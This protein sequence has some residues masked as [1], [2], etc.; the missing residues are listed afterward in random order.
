MEAVI[1]TLDRAAQVWEVGECWIVGPSA[2]QVVWKCGDAQVGSESGLH[3]RS[4]C[5]LQPYISQITLPD[6]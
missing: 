4:I 6:T 1:A 2:G 3:R 5:Y